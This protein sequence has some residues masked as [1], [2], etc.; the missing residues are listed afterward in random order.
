LT[1][2]NLD[3][4]KAEN[5]ITEATNPFKSGFVAIIGRTNSGKSTLLNALMG[6]KLSIVTP[7]PQTTRKNLK[8]VLTDT[9]AQLIFIDTPGIHLRQDSELNQK[10]KVSAMKALADSDCV[11]VL[12]DCLCGLGEEET[13]IFNRL[14]KGT[15][16]TICALNKVDAVDKLRLLPLI[17]KVQ[18]HSSAEEIIPISAKTKDGLPLLLA[19]IKKRLPIGPKYFEDDTLTDVHL[20]ELCSE[21]IRE[22]LFLELKEELPYSVI[23]EIE[24]FKETESPRGKELTEICAAIYVDKRSHKGIIIGQGGSMLKKIGTEARLEMEKLLEKKVM[25]KLYCRIQEGW[26]DDPLFLREMGF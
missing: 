23:V 15:I 25:L 24:S 17:Q 1:A 4:T 10:L 19:E 9:D 22:K 7:K 5:L 11:L 13:Q 16:P 18:K 14:S 8:G 12:I 26:R 6:T 20:R 3:A 21:I 2:L